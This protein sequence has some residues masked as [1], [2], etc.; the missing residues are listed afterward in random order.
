MN[1]LYHEIKSRPLWVTAGFGVI[2]VAMILLSYLALSVPLVPVCAIVILEALLCALLNRIPVWVH[3]LIVIAQIIG[4]VMFHKPLFML[5]MAIV[6]L[7][8][9]ALLY[10][11][12]EER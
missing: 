8:A 6:Y 4:G 10:L 3:G 7:A 5:L 12:S 9:V 2:A 11:L 1:R